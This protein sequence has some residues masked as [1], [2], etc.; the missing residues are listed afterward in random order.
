[1]SVNFFPRNKNFWIYHGSILLILSLIQTVIILLWREEKLFNFL[2]GL[3]W[4]PLFTLAVLIYRYLY[5]TRQWNQFNTGSNILLVVGYSLV[6]GLIV[7]LL[8]LGLVTPF[9]WA[10][11]EKILL[12][13]NISATTI[14]SQLVVTNWF[15]TLLFVAS[16]IFIYISITTRQLVKETELTN[17]RLQNSLKESQLANLNNQLNPH[18]LFNTLNNIKFMVRRDPVKTEKMITDLSD[19][20]RYSLE[21]NKKEKVQIGEELEVLNRYLDIVKVQMED[22][23]HFVISIPQDLYYN[24]IP[25]MILQLLIENAIK[26]GIDCLWQGGKIE[27]IA[28]T[29]SDQIEFTIINDIPNTHSHSLTGTGIGL[30]NIEQRLKL[31]Y[32]NRAVFD[33]T[34]LDSTFCV[35][36]TL[37]RELS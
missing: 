6:A 5:K 26:H 11:V 3:L 16:W 34:I 15:Q 9:F 12:K 30:A 23:L 18:F 1:M 17:L 20:L 7:A 8:M 33:A 10:D 31:L 19:I 36:L 13:H 29:V 21:S 32:G 37:P 14:L 22:R 28:E 2:C 24:L 27:L 4:L 25:P 35:S